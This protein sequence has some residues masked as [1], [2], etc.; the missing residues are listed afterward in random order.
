[1]GST[2]FGKL[3]ILASYVFLKQSSAKKYTFAAQSKAK[4][5]EAAIIPIYIPVLSSTNGEHSL[6]E[7]DLV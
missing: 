7:H 5:M 2:L 4:H 6:P 3:V 1:M